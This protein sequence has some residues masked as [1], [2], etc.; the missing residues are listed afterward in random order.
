MAHPR[1]GHQAFE[2]ENVRSR[3]DA[4]DRF[5]GELQR[6]KQRQA[7]ERH[8]QR[9]RAGGRASGRV[10]R[11]N[12]VTPPRPRRTRE[13]KLLQARPVHQVTRK[14]FNRLYF[15]MRPDGRQRGADAAWRTYAGDFDVYRREGLSA[16]TT[17]GQRVQGLASHGHRRCGRTVQRH[18]RLLEAMGVMRY[19]HVKRCG[20]LKK[21]DMDSLR[22]YPQIPNVALLFERQQER[23]TSFSLA[24]P[25]GKTG[26]SRPPSAA[27]PSRLA[28]ATAS[29]EKE[30]PPD[31]PAASDLPPA[32]P[33][34]AEL[35]PWARQM[36]LQFGLAP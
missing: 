32:E 27:K 26:L 22:V 6:R 21:G 10:R 15:V 35:T 13:Y 24:V 18:H 29:I 16:Q 23:T 33:D 7:I 5:A 1:F 30:V 25:H 17:N 20:G 19:P 36:F 34:D 11:A 12:R 4:D 14:R 8:R 31:S 28:P 2:R 3:H 9:A